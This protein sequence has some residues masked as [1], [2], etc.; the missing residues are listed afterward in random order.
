LNKTTLEWYSAKK[1]E[2]HQQN[3]EINQAG[4][5]IQIAMEDEPLFKFREIRR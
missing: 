4:T 2:V 1:E 3:I 5:G